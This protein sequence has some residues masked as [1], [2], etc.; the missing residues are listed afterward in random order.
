MRRVDVWAIVDN[1]AA[2]QGVTREDIFG[3]SRLKRIAQ[4]RFLA[5]AAVY[6]SY[7]S[8]SLTDLGLLF[9]RE[10]STIS[11]GLFRAKAERA[12]PFVRRAA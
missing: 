8:T 7:P 9:G 5:W 4:A 1:V 10:R 2:S 12:A 3:R 6:L 11:H